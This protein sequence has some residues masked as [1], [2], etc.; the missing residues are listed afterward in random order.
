MNV[1]ERTRFAVAIAGIA[2]T[3]GQEITPARIS[4]LLAALDDVPW[5]WLERA[6]TVAHRT[7]RFV[8]SP[9]EL[10][11]LAEQA[12]R[13]THEYLAL[14]PAERREVS[15]SWQGKRDEVQQ[16]LAALP[17][18]PQWPED[19]PEFAGYAAAVTRRMHD[20]HADSPTI[21]QKGARDARADEDT[22]GGQGPVPASETAHLPAGV[23]RDR[24]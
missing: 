15:A 5:R 2:E 19:G 21:A 3:L 16:L 9:G 18:P 1:D 4:G 23:R 11:D 17:R 7:A 12:S 14:P 8:P 22:Q 6:L 13:V 24:G 10:R 20:M